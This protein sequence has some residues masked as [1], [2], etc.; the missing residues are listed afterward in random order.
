MWKGRG[1]CLNVA[2][3]K[4]SENQN[5]QTPK[6]AP[7]G[8]LWHV[9]L[10]KKIVVTLVLELFLLFLGFL[11]LFANFGYRDSWTC[12]AGDSITFWVKHGV[13]GQR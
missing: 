12:R 11:S 13:G 7:N 6:V 8:T 4:S 3:W 1:R 2:F 5:P 10:K 9:E